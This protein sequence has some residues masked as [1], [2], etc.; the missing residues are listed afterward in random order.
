MTLTN[1]PNGISTSTISA[2][3]IDFPASGTLTAAV[4][5][6]T[7]GTVA[8]LVSTVETVGT[9]TGTITNANTLN[10]GTSTAITGIFVQNATLTVASVAANAS[11]EQTFAVANLGTADIIIGVQK[12]TTNAG[13][14]IGGA[15]VSAAGTIAINFANVTTA[16]I[17]PTA[18]QVYQIA[19][20]KHG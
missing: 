7:T 8:T 11:A 3:S 12:P 4:G 13:I 17:T 15:R 14:V 18:S 6:I 1:F 19:S 16:G 9:I 20:L 2:T 10:V 5:T